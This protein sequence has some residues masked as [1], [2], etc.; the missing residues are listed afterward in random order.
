MTSHGNG[1]GDVAI[2]NAINEGR[3]DGPRYQ[4]STRGV[5]W[6][7]DASGREVPDNPLDA[8]MVCTAEEARLAVRDQIAH[9]ADWIK[10]Y[11][12]GGYSFSPTE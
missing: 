4:V 7:M 6:G 12:V 11:P 1:Y 3:V 2:R 8:A 10:L 5:R 9:G